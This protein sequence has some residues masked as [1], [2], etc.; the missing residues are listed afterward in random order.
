METF[1]GVY[2]VNESYLRGYGPN[3]SPTVKSPRWLYPL[4]LCV[5]LTQAGVITEKGT[6]GEEMPP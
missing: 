5:N 1:S 3:P 6:S 4:V 2:M